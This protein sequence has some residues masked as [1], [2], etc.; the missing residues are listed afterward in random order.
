[1]Y[2]KLCQKF[3]NKVDIQYLIAAR[4]RMSSVVLPGPATCCHSAPPSIEMR[5]VRLEGRSWDSDTPGGQLNTTQPRHTVEIFGK[6]MN[7]KKSGWQ[8]T[9]PAKLASFPSAA[10][11]IFSSQ[12][13]KD[14]SSKPKL[15]WMRLNTCAKW[16]PCGST[17]PFLMRERT[18]PRGKIIKLNLIALKNPVTSYGETT[19]LM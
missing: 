9:L 12:D 19:S 15:P 8:L 5:V 7:N 13:L 2:Q 1:M 6:E 17:P 10:L 3:I 14:K 18:S 16:S 11:C 4:D